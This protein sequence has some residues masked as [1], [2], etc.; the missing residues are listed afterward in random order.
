MGYLE[1]AAADGSRAPAARTNATTRDGSSPSRRPRTTLGRA[2]RLTPAT[3]LVVLTMLVAPVLLPSTALALPEQGIYY[4]C[5]TNCEAG[6]DAAKAAGLSFVVSPPSA[7][8]AAALQA[9]GMS[10]FWSVTYHDPRPDLVQAFAANPV[11][12]GWYI[13]DEP[14]SQD[15]GIERWWAQQVH[16]LDPVHPTLSVHFGCS[17]GQA[18]GAMR[19]FKDTVDWLGTD[20]YPVGPGS[21]RLTG[22]AFAAGGRLARRSRKAFWA[23]TQAA[24][25][26]AMCGESC[27]RPETTW[28]SPRQMQIMRDCAAAAG[29]RVIAW[30]A[31]EHVLGGGERRLWDL[32]AAVRSPQRRCPR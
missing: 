25:W 4:G 6:L 8:M 5:Y 18:S 17:A 11:T 21:S 12:R 32:A 9:R 29:A 7:S 3:L 13:A 1:P 31:L 16:L 22:P 24:S 15:L 28:P 30:F 27:G 26:A 23:V 19:P 10:A 14:W 20:C 2:R